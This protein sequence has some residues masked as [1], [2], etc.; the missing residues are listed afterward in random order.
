[1]SLNTALS[2]L[3]AAQTEIAAASHNIANVSTIGFRGSRTEFAD[4]YNS[5]P[6]SVSRTTTG[7]GTQVTRV[8]QDY[9]QG[10]IVGTGNVLD[11]AIEGPGFFALRQPA[12]AAEATA[13][14]LYSRSGAFSMSADGTIVNGSGQELLGWPVSAEGQALNQALSASTPLRVPLA[15]G[16]AARTSAIR[17]EVSLPGDPAMAGAQAAV[18]PPAGFDPADQTSWAHRTMVPMLDDAGNAIEAEAYFVRV[19]NPDATLA[20]T[21]YEVHLFRAGIELPPVA[22]NGIAFGPDGQPVAGSAALAF[23]SGA[24]AVSLDLTESALGNGPFAVRSVS[25]N[26]AQTAPLSSLG[27]DSEG[28]VWATYGADDRTAV[29]KLLLVNFAN[30]QGLRVLGGAAYAETAD[31]GIAVAGSPNGAGF[32]ALRSGALEKANVDLTEEL[33]MLI[34]AQRNYQASAKA[35][36]TASSMMQTIMN[37]RS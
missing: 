5:S 36:E 2:G 34:S 10:S 8:A 7:S 1:M 4:I 32:G 29:G 13:L 27:V 33:V 3:T 17:L 23:G 37:L 26:G 31:S 11:L 35:M 15:T 25:H 19:A 18:P 14:T 24:G 28:T 21:R 20:E 9:S 12:T 16:E 22:G 30:P 6:F